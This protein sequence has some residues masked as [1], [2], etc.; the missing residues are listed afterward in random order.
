MKQAMRKRLIHIV[1]GARPNFI[2]A[3][4]VYRV[5][6]SLNQFKLQLINTG[7]HYDNNMS[8][9]FFDEL[10]MKPPDVNLEVGSGTHA[11]QTARIMERYERILLE[12]R[13]DLVMVFGDVNSTIACALTAVKMHIHV[14]HIEA[15]LRSFDRTM[16]EEINRILTDQ[17]SEFL[18][19]TCRDAD[20]NLINEG[21]AEEKI[22]FVGNTMIDTLVAFEEHFATSNIHEIIGL[23]GSYALLTFH[24][25]S[26]VD[27]ELVLTK[28]IRALEV[29][30]EIIPC[31]FPIHP[32]TKQ[33]LK[34]YG[35]C[36]RINT[37]P[38]FHLL[39]PIGYIDFM[40]LQRDADVVITDSGGIQ[41]ESTFF[42]VPCL[43]IRNSTE[44]PITI[45]RGTNKIVGTDY[46]NIPSEVRVVIKR[47]NN[48]SIPELWDGHAADRI[49][50]II[51][52]LMSG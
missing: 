33:K 38:R 10:V 51:G 26:N 47:K 6:E 13:P 4:A 32:R 31:I 20:F 30:A 45:T 41:E 12:T 52:E 34:D 37:N 21:I 50:A 46:D 18:F 7:Q 49:S 16:P 2:K 1:V 3:N 5:L 27:D 25:P 44:R 29:T 40:R 43:T 11:S 36:E 39:A 19:T 9:L 22:H 35:I 24:R 23:N 15:G 14:A 48:N 8:R 42:S 17:I 28:L